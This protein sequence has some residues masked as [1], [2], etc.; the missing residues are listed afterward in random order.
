MSEGSKAFRGFSDVTLPVN[1]VSIHAR[2]FRHANPDAPVLL[3][4]H[5][6]PQ[7][8]FIWHR[9]V[10]RLTKEY[11]V[12]CPDLR[13]YGDSDKP[14]SH[15]PHESYSKRV[16]ALDMVELMRVLGF[17]RFAVVGHDRGGRVAHRLCLDH[18]EQVEKLCLLD[19]S[20]TL[21][22]YQRTDMAFARAYFHWFFLI[23]PAP[24]PETLIAANASAVLKTFLGAWTSGAASAQSE[25]FSSEAMAEYERC[26]NGVKAIHASCED[27]RASAGIDLEHDRQSD[28][29]GVKLTM[30]CLVLWGEDGIV[31]RM[32]DPLADWQEK[33]SSSV[34]GLALKA[35]HFLAEQ[36]PEQVLERLLPFLASS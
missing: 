35:G 31:G 36:V 19:I 29:D 18:P 22:M 11:S 2:V 1:H 3:L 10:G 28:Q 5:G 16:M 12:V 24:L 4:L 23:Q 6:F 25:I 9:L 7:T 26:W 21:T 32:F 17:A 14:P 30:P 27:Y 33:S 34:T 20:P 15:A 13:G 8:H